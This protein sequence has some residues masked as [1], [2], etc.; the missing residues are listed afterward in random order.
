[1]A[2]Q[3]ITN[4]KP[5][6]CP[7]ANSK[8]AVVWEDD[9]QLRYSNQSFFGRLNVDD[10]TAYGN[11][12]NISVPE[13]FE[14]VVNKELSKLAKQ[15]A[16]NPLKMYA[17]GKVRFQGK[18][19]YALV[20]CTTDL[21]G[22]D[23][24]LC[25]DRAIEDVLKAFYFS[26]GAR[27]LSRSCYL[28]YELYAFYEGAKFESPI[29]NTKGG[30]RKIWWITILTILSAC[31]GILVVSYVC[32]AMRKSKKRGNREILGQHDLFHKENDTKAQE[33]PNISL[34][35][36]HAATNKFS[37]SNKLGE[38]GFGPVYK[39]VLRDGKEVAIKRLSS[40]SEQGSEEFTNEVL[41]I[42]KLQ[43]KN[44]VR[45][46]GFCV[47]KEEKLLVYEYM[48]NS[49]LDVI[50]FD[51]KKRAQLDWSRRVSII[52]GIA[53]GILYLHE[54]SRLRIIHR[55]LKASNV[56][57]D[58]E[59]CPKISD[60]GMARIFG[61]S[62][63]Q[64]NTA[65]IVG[66]YG[67]MAPE[68]AM[69]GL[70][71][72]KSDVYG[73]GV[74]L[75]EII[76]GRKN[77]GFHLTKR[78]RAPSL[79]AYAWKL[80][81]EGKGLELVDPLLVGSC[82]PE[83]F[84]RYLHIGLLC[85]QEDANDRPTMSSA[86]VMLKSETVSLTQPEKP[87]FNTGSFSNHHNE[88]GADSCSVNVLTVSDIMPRSSQVCYVVP[89]SMPKSSSFTNIPNTN[90]WSLSKGSFFAIEYWKS[91]HH[92][93]TKFDETKMDT[94]SVM[95]FMILALLL[96][97]TV[98]GADPLFTLCSSG[99]GNYTPSTQ[100]ETN[101]KQL[102]ES[103]SFN[104][105]IFGGFYSNTIGTGR[106]T[107]YGQTLCRG[108]VNSTVCQKCVSDASHEVFN[109]CKSKDAFIWY[110]L[111][112][113]HY[114]YQTFFSSKVYTG[115]YPPQNDQ[116]KNVSDAHYFGDG[117]MYLME[118]LSK[119]SVFN[120]PNNMF[121]I[122]Q[123]ELSRNRTIYGLEQCTRDMSGSTWCHD[124]LKSA[125]TELQECCSAHEGGVIVSRNCNVRFGL[126]RFFNDTSSSL[127]YYSYPK[128]DDWKTWKMVVIICASTI[129]FAVLI[130]LCAVHFR[131]KRLKIVKDEERSEHVLAHDLASP[132]EV[133]ITEEGVLVT[134]EELPFVDVETIKIATDDFSDSNKLGQGGFGTVYKGVLPDGKE[135]A[136]K[137]LSRKSWQG[138]EEFKNEV[139]LIAKLQHR[140]LVRLLACGFEGEEKL[141]LY[142]FMPNKSLDT[143]I[144]D[145]QRRAELSWETYHNIIKGIARGLLYLH[146]D[147]RLRIIHRDLKPANVLLDH[148]MVAKI[149]DFGMARIFCANQNTANTKRVVGTYGY[150]A[151]EYAMEGLFSVKSDV[152][153]FGVIILEII[154]GKRNSGFYLTEHAKTLVA[155]AW[156]LWKDG[157]EVEFV[158]PSLLESSPTKE[159]LRCMHIGLLCLQEDPKERPTVSDVVVLLGS[160]SIELPEPKKPAIFAASRI[161]PIHESST[162][163]PTPN[164]LTLS[165]VLPR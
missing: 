48:P 72:V 35:S 51:S 42:M 143:F 56:L 120:P 86:V 46:L 58:N 13:K 138:L 7:N 112:Q 158:E 149:S 45:L 40:C 113:V 3:H 88:G 9:C 122:G 37:D 123:I 17:T 47:E 26:I 67:Y 154:S 130:V 14:K 24:Q 18:M 109:S 133:T 144:F 141:L 89:L 44:L 30:G 161:P 71:S 142:E 79:I 152:F 2:Q 87:A 1:M 151:P 128:G 31:L 126:N 66:T 150:M 78:T 4:P 25:L 93:R 41:L 10:N 139:I 81:D 159:I 140:N 57:L 148:G 55:D 70:Y 111:C 121:A 50:L 49:S 20:Q 43:H 118:S 131:Q 15:A 115:K 116:K 12:K 36:I 91:K 119:E 100:F 28:R 108:D 160:D 103:L 153:S 125:L 110:D 114:S 63:G 94:L 5:D 60:F 6:V 102:L 33:Y 127:F 38:G 21:S 145:S 135:V 23:C 107:V 34:A 62:E 73:F 146:E 156:N 129:L 53:R 101:L 77:T 69:E 137:R 54:D 99:D 165:I 106:D 39:G 83:E 16:F 74:L 68:Y 162:S 65:T 59:M 75:L 124:C 19:V 104:T 117:L 76:T 164:G 105:S 90:S 163:C 64:A 61:G 136:V 97:A 92:L 11:A 22:D 147:S 132:T 27:L 134:S 80:W 95:L 8:E 98:S 155:Y 84:L 52:S 157:K 96:P 82:D 32:L 29:P 85:V